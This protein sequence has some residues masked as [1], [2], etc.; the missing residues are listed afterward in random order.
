MRPTKT[1]SAAGSSPCTYYS[2]PRFDARSCEP[3]QP[4]VRVA[5]SYEPFYLNQTPTVRYVLKSPTNSGR[6]R[7]PPRSPFCGM[8]P[9]VRYNVECYIMRTP[10][11][12]QPDRQQ[13]LLQSGSPNLTTSSRRHALSP[14][15]RRADPGF[16]GKETNKDNGSE[17]SAD[18]FRHI[19]LH[20]P[21]PDADGHVESVQ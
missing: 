20:R 14:A 10:C 3:H 4:D 12:R 11:P 1:C 15:I 9:R 16:Q 19:R 17:L 7:T 8:R 6:V 5:A 13:P 18:P 2:H 21:T